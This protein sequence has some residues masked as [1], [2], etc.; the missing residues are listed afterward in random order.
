M[1]TKS[2]IHVENIK[3]GGCGNSITNRLMEQHGVNEVEVDLEEGAIKLD[4]DDIFEL[5]E[6]ESL[7][8]KMGYPPVGENNLRAK[9]KSYV[10]CMVG[11]MSD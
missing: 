10:S 5:S 9:A 4:H 7:L 1:K 2:I 11:R 8:T 6:I 3:C